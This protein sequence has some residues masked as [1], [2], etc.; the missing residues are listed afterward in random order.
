MPLISNHRVGPDSQYIRSGGTQYITGE[1]VFP[2]AP[3]SAT[4]ML[5]AEFYQ[6]GTYVL[7]DYSASVSANPVQNLSRLYVEV[8]GLPN[9]SGSV[10]VTNNTITKQILVTIYGNSNNGTQYV[11]GTLT[12]SGPITITLSAFTHGAPGTYTLFS[13]GSLVGSITDIT[14]VPPTGRSVDTTVSP[15]GC[16][17]SGSTITVKLI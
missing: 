15:N 12:I 1:L 11:D 16:A 7:F 4:I 2:A 5:N 8:S 14:I 10:V 3:G 17:I 9:F 6:T 13:Y